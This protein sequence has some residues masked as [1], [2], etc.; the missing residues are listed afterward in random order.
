M[1]PAKMICGSV[2]YAAAEELV[3]AAAAVV[4]AGAVVDVLF[5][6]AVVKGT[7][8]LPATMRPL[9]AKLIAAELTTA[10][11][12]PSVKVLLPTI[13]CVTTMLPLVI[14]V[15]YAVRTILGP[16]VTS[17]TGML[18]PDDSFAGAVAL[19]S[20]ATPGHFSMQAFML[21]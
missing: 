14:T 12:L 8:E 6:A 4:E 2:L 18:F 20:I 16:N 11:A 9:F 19:V 10:G 17:A 5:G 3:V 21:L 1:Q 13:A 7:S 15:S